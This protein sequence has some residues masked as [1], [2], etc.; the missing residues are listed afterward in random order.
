[1]AADDDWAHAVDLQEGLNQVQIANAEEPKFNNPTLSIS[2]HQKP[3]GSSDGERINGSFD[4]Q[5]NEAEP[6][7]SEQSFLRK[8]LR[9]KLVT[10]QHEL[11]VQQRDPSSPL[12]SVK[13]FEE[14]NLRKDL[15]KGIYDMGFN[16][17]S[18]IQETALPMLLSRQPQNLIAQSQSGTG[19]TAAFVLT[20][21]SR[22]DTTNDSPQ[23]LCL[24]PTFELALQTGKVVEIMGSAMNNLKICYALKGIRLQKGE[25]A[26]GQII[27]GTP[28]TTMD[29]VLKMKSIDPKT[30]KVFVLDEADVMIDTQGHKDQTTRIHRTLN[31]ETCQ[32]LFFSA[33]YDDDVMK[34]AEKI[35]PHANIIKLKRE[36]ETLSNIKQYQV[37]CV[38]IDKKYDALA[39]IYATLS[40]GQAVIFCH[41]RHTAKWLAEK[42]HAE[43]Y[44][45]ALLSGELDVA[46]RAKILKRFRDGKE[47]VLVTT[48]VCA[49]GI[50][51]EQVTLVVNFDLPMTKDRHPDY[52]TYIHRIGRTGR[53]GKSGVAI[54]FVSDTH[55]SHIIQKIANHFKS[56]IPT[57]DA[58]DYDDLENKLTEK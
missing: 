43:G 52:E 6:S 1:M 48:N 53:F 56:I 26:R 22:I 18:K 50:D 40:V 19:K 45:V 17:P 3:S 4:Q 34:F 55:D 44:V 15:L 12:Y 42:M 23:C 27:I 5:E 47:R 33:T 13:S 24:S 54:N 49:R 11:E 37:H 2:N 25:K 57:L 41:T 9:E 31:K 39:N 36:E 38:D 8:I 35:V 28:G 46:S 20:M 10:T 14:L 16:R 51:V 29:W 32:F 7:A 58:C 21:L 30:I